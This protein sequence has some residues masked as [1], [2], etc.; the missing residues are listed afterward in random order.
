MNQVELKK[1]QTELASYII[2]M[3]CLVI[4]GNFLGDNGIAYFA[5]AF[6]CFLLPIILLTH[7][8]EDTLGK[9]LRN[10]T[11]KGQY[12]NAKKFRRNIFGAGAVLGLAGSVALFAAAELLGEKLFGLTYSVAMICILAPVVLLRMVASILLGYFQG[13]GTELPAIISYI[14]RQ[15]GIVLLA[16]LFVKLLGNYGAKVSALLREENFTAM[17]CGM[18]YALAM[19]VS[20]ILVVLFLG[21]VYQGSRGRAKKGVNDGMR[22]QETFAGQVAAVVSNTFPLTLGALIGHIPVWTGFFSTRRAWSR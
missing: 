7:K 5:V 12:K 22:V 2:G 3:V 9:L 21:F 4:I 14:M 17:Y 8:L 20:E 10:R 15:I 11:S 19:L 6:E 1:R 13:E 16:V 18:G